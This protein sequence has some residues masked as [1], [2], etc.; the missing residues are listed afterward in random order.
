MKIVL[1]MKNEDGDE[2]SGYLTNLLLITRLVE[3]TSN[4]EG[5]QLAQQGCKS[6]AESISL[7]DG[8]GKQKLL[9]YQQGFRLGKPKV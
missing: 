6:K 2:V 9:E 3:P 4:G 5:M 1:K 8:G 7:M